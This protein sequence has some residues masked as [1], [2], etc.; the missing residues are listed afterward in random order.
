MAE[1]LKVIG[2]LNPA[3]A[4][5]TTLYTVPALTQTVV[6]TI[7]VCNQGVVA[8]FRVAI[9]PNGAAID[10][11]HYLAYDVTLYPG[12][13]QTMTLGITLDAADVITVRADTATVSFNAFG[14]EVT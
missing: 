2:Q 7:I 10:P 12:T 1:T 6:S 4:T 8:T 11:K 3:A 5:D 9:R 13:S 14:L